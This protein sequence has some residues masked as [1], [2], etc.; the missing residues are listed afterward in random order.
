MKNF[1]A[2]LLILSSYLFAQENI[3]PAD[4]KP[5]AAKTKNQFALIKTS[6]GDMVVELFNDAAPKT[7]ANF[8][9]LAEGKIE[10]TDVK[11]SEK[12]KGNYYDGLTFHRCLKDFMIQ[13]GDPMGTGVGGPGYSFADEINGV[14]L[15]LDK[16][17]VP[18]D[19]QGLQQIVFKKTC[20][21][22]KIKSKE[23]YDKLEQG[24]FA[25]KFGENVT[26]LKE[27]ASSMSR[28]D[29][30]LFSGYAYDNNLPSKKLVK[31]SLAMANAGPNTNGS[32]FFINVV[33]T[34]HLDG[35]HTNFGQV[36]KGIEV[37]VEISLLGVPPSGKPS[38]EIK[39]ISIRE[40]SEKD[41]NALISSK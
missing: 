3:K 22:L 37:A 25:K 13:G 40:L 5:E 4:T 14:I 23:E 34:P 7:V 41:K 11:T 29:I 21:D 15:G 20:A 28:L 36:I 19:Q 39:I 9:G 24:L 30:N 10:Y 38:E 33:D 26:L 17:K 2:F 6:K 32:Q 35:L 27:K 31:G 18:L 1:V 8:L 16:E 12:K